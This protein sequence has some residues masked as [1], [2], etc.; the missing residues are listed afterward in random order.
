M[1]L[2]SYRIRETKKP[3]VEEFD[4]KKAVLDTKA[5]KDLIDSLPSDIDPEIEKAVQD[6]L[7]SESK[8]KDIEEMKTSMDKVSS[9]GKKN[10]D[11]DMEWIK[12]NETS[13]GKITLSNNEK[14]DNE[15]KNVLNNELDSIINNLESEQK[16]APENNNAALDFTE[17]G[18]NMIEKY[19]TH[20]YQRMM[21]FEETSKFLDLYSK[22]FNVDRRDAHEKLNE[23]I[24]RQVNA[25]MTED[26]IKKQGM[27]QQQ[28]MSQTGLFTQE[29]G[30]NFLAYLPEDILE[31]YSKLYLQSF[32]VKRSDVNRMITDSFDKAYEEKINSIETSNRVRG[33][34]VIKVLMLV[35]STFLL[36]VTFIGLSFMFK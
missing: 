20:N 34:S 14:D 2:D 22:A 32:L 27:K 4:S 9:F 30:N 19:E 6:I 29:Y 21:N 26:E 3:K 25:V 7:D 28:L 8:N 10:S 15:T 35:T 17:F 5:M 23:T 12:E 11:M 13:E 36:S 31:N 16:N 24:D 33:F 1:G 18:N